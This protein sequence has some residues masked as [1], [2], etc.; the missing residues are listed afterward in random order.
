M[1]DQHRGNADLVIGGDFNLTVGNRHHSEIGPDGKTWTT[2]DSDL[3]TQQRLRE[4]FGHM[5]C[6]QAAHPDAPLAQTLRWQKNPVPAYHCD[7][8]FVPQSWKARLQACEVLADKAWNS[9]SDHNPVIV[10]FRD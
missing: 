3:Q 10:E 5:N 8:I 4:K 9:P 6:W 7:G 2:S 1:I